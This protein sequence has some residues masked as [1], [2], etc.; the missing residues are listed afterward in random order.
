M[1]VKM[2][3]GD[4]TNRVTDPQLR[5]VDESK[6]LLDTDLQRVRSVRGVKWAVPMIL[7][8]KF[9]F[10]PPALPVYVGQQVNV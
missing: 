6:L 10:T 8:M 4:R 7:Q 1:A 9:R 3:I 5:S 2:L